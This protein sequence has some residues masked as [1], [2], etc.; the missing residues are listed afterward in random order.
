[1]PQTHQLEA[2]QGEFGRQYTDRNLL[3]VDDM[4]RELEAYYAGVK[5]TEL[6]CEF[7]GPDRLPAGRVLEV[8]C[9]VGIQ[10]RMLQRINPSL[11]FWGVEPQFY[12][13]SKAREQSPDMNLAAGTAFEL[14]FLGDY[15]DVVMTN[16]VLIHIHPD[17][18]PTA[19]R[20]IYRVAR[21]FIFFHEYYAPETTQIPYYGHANL[22][23]KTDFK[24]VCQKLFPDLRCVR[25]QYLQYP[26]PATAVLLTDQIALLEKP[27]RGHGDQ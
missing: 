14:P 27:D 12:A 7:L 23:W 4:D 26:D 13:L 9:N 21:R 3:S 11:S 15:F 6:F 25:E 19:L 2:W 16:G 8:G 24:A 20:E 22:L 17:H 1:M 10:L 18:L 5:K